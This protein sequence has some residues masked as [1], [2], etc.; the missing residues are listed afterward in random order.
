MM[1]GSGYCFAPT[2]QLQDN[3]PT[4]NVVAMYDAVHRCGLYGESL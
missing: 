2:H 1:P 4:Q 3:S